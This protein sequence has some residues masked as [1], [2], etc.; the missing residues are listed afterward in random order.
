MA[1]EVKRQKMYKYFRKIIIIIVALLL[2]LPSC[3]PGGKLVVENQ[4]KTE[5][6]IYFASV[7]IDGTIDKLTEQGIIPSQTTRTFG[8]VFL[9]DD[10]VNRIEAKD[11]QGKVLFSH[12]YKMRDLEKINWKITIP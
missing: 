7:R 5:I 8:I 6:T 4:N 12:D 3:E 9:G 1:V 11:T 2:I 10:W